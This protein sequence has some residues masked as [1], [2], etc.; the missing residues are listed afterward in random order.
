MKNEN[1]KNTIDVRQQKEK[2][3]LIK[4]LSEM[5]IIEI[6]CKRAG[7]GR[8]SY[9]RWLKEDSEF[10]KKADNALQ[11]GR[12]LINDMSE[13]Q[14]VQMIKEKK[15]PAIALWLKNNSSRYGNK[16]M[17]RRPGGIMPELNREQEKIFRKA[18][19]MSSFII[20]KNNYGKKN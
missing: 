16:L 7:V 15:M 6:A 3:A 13:S 4:S 17:Q 1:Y 8:A 9:Y 19:A 12:E 18:I 14:I 5:P 10:L 11:E 20:K 2:E